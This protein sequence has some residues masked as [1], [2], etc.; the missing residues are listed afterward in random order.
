[1]EPEPEER[2]TQWDSGARTDDSWLSPRS[3]TE[4]A[5]KDG[6]VADPLEQYREGATMV[7]R[8]SDFSGTLRSQSHLF[9]EGKFEGEMEAEATVVISESA[10]VK[11]KVRAKDVIVAGTLNGTV[12]AGGR[13]HAMPTARVEAEVTSASLKVEEG[14][15]INC[16]FAMK[17]Q[18]EGR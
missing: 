14:S 9:V 12:E 18:G 7:A 2:M 1:M 15:Q 11:A 16:H 10:N 6:A 5:A 17:A 8:D 4:V 3:S 13:F